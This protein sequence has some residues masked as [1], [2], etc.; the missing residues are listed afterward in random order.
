MLKAPPC[1]F[2]SLHST[3]ALSSPFSMDRT[4]GP[5]PE[6]SFFHRSTALHVDIHGYKGSDPLVLMN[7]KV[8]STTETGHLLVAM[9]W[10]GGGV[11]E[12]RWS[13]HQLSR[14]RYMVPVTGRSMWVTE[15]KTPCH[16]HVRGKKNITIQRVISLCGSNDSIVAQTAEA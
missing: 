15:F 7:E 8:P 14:C 13:A 12:L 9:A 16:Y 2:F 3:C 1:F 10:K 11:C 5:C 6:S 4:Q